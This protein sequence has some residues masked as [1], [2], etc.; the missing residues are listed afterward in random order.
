M[1]S[2]LRCGIAA[3]LAV[4]MVGPSAD[5]GE[6]TSSQSVGLRI[7]VIAGE[8]AVNVIQQKTAVAPIVEVRDR[9]DQPVAGALVTF[10]IRGGK[11]ASFASGTQTLNVTTDA[12]G[13]AAVTDITP[14]ARG[15]YR[16]E[17]TASF[18]S[19]TANLTISQTNVATAAQAQAIGAG[20]A[21]GAGAVAAGAAAAAAGG[22]GGLSGV[23]IG[24]IAAAAGGGALV[25][26]KA[27]SGGDSTGP[28]SAG[29]TQP[30]PTGPP[31]ATVNPALLAAA[32]TYTLVQI[33]GSSLP[34]LTV[35]S[36]PNPCPGFTDSG[37]LT[38]TINPEVYDLSERS[39]IEC[40]TGPGDQ[41]NSHNSGTW[42]LQGG[43]IT[44]TPGGSG[45]FFVGPG[46][47]SGSTLTFPFDAPHANAGNPPLRVNSTWT[48]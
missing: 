20:T 22:G 34:A 23:A 44:F 32:G 5:S 29:P 17:V 4:S 2:I 7:I 6:P 30:G 31:T 12:A 8:D 45:Q 24:A 28:T 26:V 16:I 11:T 38:L 14:L 33:N 1:D 10:A 9:N 37:T 47:L 46:T 42:S 43:T 39:H 13:R 35:A 3:A 25:A 27:A 15:S 40:R 48:K 18:E 21:A 41:F 19:Q 36:P